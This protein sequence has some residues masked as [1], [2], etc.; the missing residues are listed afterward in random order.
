VD[1]PPAAGGK[2]HK[3]LLVKPQQE[4]RFCT[5]SD[6]VRVAYALAGQGRP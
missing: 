5:T 4:I 3:P 2:A 6:G 1:E